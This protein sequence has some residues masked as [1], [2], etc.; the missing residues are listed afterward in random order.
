MTFKLLGYSLNT[1]DPAEV[2][3]ALAVIYSGEALYTS[4]ENENMAYEVYVDLDPNTTQM[5][6]DKW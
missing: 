1:S 4:S 3:A 5:Y 6:N 2:E